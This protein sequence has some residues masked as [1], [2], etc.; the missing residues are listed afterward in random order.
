MG[1]T[2]PLNAFLSEQ[3]YLRKLQKTNS[4]TSLAVNWTNSVLL[5]EFTDVM[6]ILSTSRQRIRTFCKTVNKQH[7][8]AKQLFIGAIVM[9]KIEKN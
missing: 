5:T 9:E 3:L 1:N 8:F 6:L 4:V 2:F 7:F